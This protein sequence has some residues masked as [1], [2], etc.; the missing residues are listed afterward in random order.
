[1]PRE[2]GTY[3]GGKKVRAKMEVATSPVLQVMVEKIPL[4]YQHCPTKTDKTASVFLDI[5]SLYFI[6]I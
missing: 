3:V 1:M 4:L 2:V 6:L 5:P